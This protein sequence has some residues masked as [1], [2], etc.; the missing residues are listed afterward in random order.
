M[1]MPNFRAAG[2]CGVEQRQ[3]GRRDTEEERSI[4]AHDRLELIEH[5]SEVSNEKLTKAR[6]Y[7]L[8]SRRGNFDDLVTGVTQRRA[9]V[10]DDLGDRRISR[11]AGRLGNNRDTHRHSVAR[12]IEW[13]VDRPGITRVRAGEHAQCDAHVPDPPRHWAVRVHQLHRQEVVL[14]RDEARMGYAP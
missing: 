3:S 7:L 4:L 9:G 10:T 1:Y 14:P 11:A 5:R 6:R 2:G 12:S 8:V 13:S